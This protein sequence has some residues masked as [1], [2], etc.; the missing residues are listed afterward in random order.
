MNKVSCLDM[1][2]AVA[3]Y[4]GYRQNTVVPNISY[5]LWIHEV[6]VLIISKSGY[7]TEVE[8]KTSIS[9]LKADL[10][11]KHGHSSNKIK[12]LYF[13][14]PEE[15]KEKALP[16]IPERAG[17][18]IVKQDQYK[19]LWCEVIKSP[20]VNKEARALTQEELTK[21]GYLAALRIWNLKRIIRG[22]KNENSHLRNNTGNNKT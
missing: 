10:N 18:I 2:I 12:Y 14:I 6:D 21:L 5:G 15:L 20:M 16:L 3:Q 19:Y 11:K 7:A 4:F 8:I 9:D 17:L 1:E 22:L 13:A